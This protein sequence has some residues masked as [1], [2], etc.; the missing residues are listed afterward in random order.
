VRLLREEDIRKLGSGN[1]GATNVWRAYGARFGAPVMALDVAK[2]FVPARWRRCRSA[3]RGPSTSSPAQ[4]RWPCWSS[5]A[6][7]SP[8]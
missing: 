2:G 5:T 4:Q 6:R 1:I 8:V 7:T 3:N